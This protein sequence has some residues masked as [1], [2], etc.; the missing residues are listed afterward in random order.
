EHAAATAG[1]G[2]AGDLARRRDDVVDRPVA[3]FD[4]QLA[5][6]LDGPAVEVSEGLD[7]GQAGNRPERDRK[8]PGDGAAGLGEHRSAAREP[9]GVGALLATKRREGTASFCHLVIVKKTAILTATLCMLS[10]G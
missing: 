5:K 1:L 6:D 2:G 8:G 7:E 3:G 9:A 10:A 4:A